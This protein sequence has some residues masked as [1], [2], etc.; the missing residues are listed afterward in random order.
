MSAYQREI[1]TKV[2]VQILMR[3]VCF[4]L[5]NMETGLF[6]LLNVRLL[7]NNALLCVFD[8]LLPEFLVILRK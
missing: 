2:Y 6:W 5:E 4:L 7:I 8:V 1:I 3:C